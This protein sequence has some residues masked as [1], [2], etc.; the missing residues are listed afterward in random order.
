MD[1]GGS[2][3]P[4]SASLGLDRAVAFSQSNPKRPHSSAFGRYER[5]K[6]AGTVREA[7]GLGASRED[8]A[9][10]QRR[11]F[12][13]LR[14]DGDGRE[15]V[16]RIHLEESS[17]ASQAAPGPRTCPPS[18]AGA[19][20][21]PPSKRRRV[22]EPQGV[23]EPQGEP[24]SASSS[25]T[26]PGNPCWS[27]PSAP[28]SL[29]ASA[30]RR[31]AD[32]SQFL[33]L[34]RGGCQD[35]RRSQT[36]R[37]DVPCPAARRPPRA[38]GKGLSQTSHSVAR[39]AARGT[40]RSTGPSGGG[41]VPQRTGVATTPRAAPGEAA[42]DPGQQPRQACAAAVARRDWRLRSPSEGWDAPASAAC[43]SDAEAA[44]GEVRL[45][46]GLPFGHGPL[47]ELGRA[48]E[49]LEAAATLA[50]A[51]RGAA[52]TSQALEREPA[53]DD[54]R[55]VEPSAATPAAAE[56]SCPPG[57]EAGER[58]IGVPPMA[59]LSAAT[60]T[61]PSDLTNL[62]AALSAV[63]SDGGSH[64]YGHGAGQTRDRASVRPTAATGTPATSSSE[65]VFGLSAALSGVIGGDEEGSSRRHGQ[66]DECTNTEVCG[67]RRS[68]APEGRGGL[69]ATASAAPPPPAPTGDAQRPS[70]GGAGTGGAEAD[71]AEEPS[72]GRRPPRRLT[73]T[74][75]GRSAAR[76]S[77]R[78]RRTVISLSPDTPP[79]AAARG[80]RAGPGRVAAVLVSSQSEP[81]TPGRDSQV[82][83]VRPPKARPASRAPGIITVQY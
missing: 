52:G 48:Q 65:G 21:T 18:L 70:V 5:Y 64:T 40:A 58:G 54:A 53:P 28:L 33:S 74:P 75:R 1:A 66:G 27:H 15:A 13:T 31:P 67:A 2:P 38:S 4:R 68:H 12:M 24:G 3:S 43:A 51:P 37:P 35:T 62:S 77:A 8:I 11:R 41:A 50:A 25:R 56:R 59:A 23:R 72:S 81:P 34:L 29:S 55:L 46:W 61:S 79:P 17:G 36:P 44:V 16:H 76:K 83:L 6:A 60:G 26:V 69:A 49:A 30:P 7:L 10:D 14:P 19:G 39:G 78:W 57:C 82:Q 63:M 45:R 80:S 22:H 42:A 73:L 71:A 32:A 9:H 20:A 47:E